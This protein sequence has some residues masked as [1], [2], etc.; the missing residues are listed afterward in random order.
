MLIGIIGENCTGKST[1]AGKIQERFGGETV[2]GK[3]YLRMAKNEPEAE[4]LFREKM[5]KAV[6]GENLIYVITQPDHLRLLP[7]GAVRILVTADLD[8]IKARFRERMHGKLPAPVEKMLEAHHGLF[9]SEPCDF[10]YDGVHGDP[11]ALCDT[12]IR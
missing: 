3:D 1:L 2:T 12:I 6:E 5:Q 9:D 10:R 8:T 7:E 4:K 11:D